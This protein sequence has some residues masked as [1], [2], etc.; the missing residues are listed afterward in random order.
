MVSTRATLARLMQVQNV[1][2]AACPLL[3]TITPSNLH[4]NTN[5]FQFAS[6]DSIVVLA[7][8]HNLATLQLT[9]L[10]LLYLLLRN[11]FE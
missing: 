1:S 11:Y 10:S 7:K 6:R 4:M 2:N 3:G 5:M 8:G 9:L